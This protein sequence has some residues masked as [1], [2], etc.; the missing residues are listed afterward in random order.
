[1]SIY[2]NTKSQH[3]STSSSIS[4]TAIGHTHSLDMAISMHEP[5]SQCAHLALYCM[6]CHTGFEFLLALSQEISLHW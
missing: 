6:C 2:Y 1:M 5:H 3:F 4:N